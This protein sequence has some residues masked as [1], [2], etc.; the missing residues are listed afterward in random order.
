ME[1]TTETN[2]AP[3]CCPGCG[4]KGHQ[5]TRTAVLGYQCME[6]RAARLGNRGPLRGEPAVTA[7]LM[8]FLAGRAFTLD[9]ES[10]DVA[11]YF[12]DED[13]DQFERARI[14][15]LSVGETMNLGGGAAPIF[16]VERVA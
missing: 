12:A 7:R 4:S 15:A 6:C 16:V 11:R 9:G 2:N 10:F 5:L 8:D 3:I 14:L 13:P 1:A